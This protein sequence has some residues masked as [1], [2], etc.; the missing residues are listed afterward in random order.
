[1]MP[2]QPPQGQ[3]IP[4]PPGPPPVTID[5][6]M[7]LLRDGIQRRFRI[8]IETDST[9]AGNEAE[10]RQDRTEFI[11]ATT[12]FV[13]TWGPIV[14]QKPVM[15]QLAGELL[16]F[17][18]RAFRVGRSLE[19][20]IE[21]T[22]EKL[23]MEAAQP[24]PPPQPSPDEQIKL[25]TAQVKAQAETQNTQLEGQIKQMEAQFRQQEMAMEARAKEQEAA[26]KSQEQKMDAILKLL[27]HAQTVR[28]HHL[29]AQQAERSH[30]L[31]MEVA[32]HKATEANK[33]TE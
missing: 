23:D 21:E 33:A 7:Q 28:E 12:K 14:E 22:V 1:M 26:L 3:P 5:A 16:L 8:D 10:E 32:E 4:Q 15:S 9:V 2:V 30:E 24:K 31:A 13:E 20:V 27:E 29:N 6:V 18:T 17:C 19:E 25:Q 11:S